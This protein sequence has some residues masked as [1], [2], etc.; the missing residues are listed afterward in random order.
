MSIEFHSGDAPPVGTPSFAP[1]VIDAAP[2]TP[3]GPAP[4]LLALGETFGGDFTG[5]SSVEDANRAALLIAQSYAQAG[6]VQHPPQPPQNSQAPTPPAAA[7]EEED[8]GDLDPK[9]IARLKRLDSDLKQTRAQAQQFQDRLTHDQLMLQQQQ[10]QDILNRALATIDSLADPRYG[11]AGNRSFTQDIARENLL[12]TADR[13][14][15]GMKSTGKSIP[16]I[17]K[18]VHMAVLAESG[19]LPTAK[20]AAAG[21]GSNGAPP[22]P[23]GGGSKDGA[24]APQQRRKTGTEVDS[25]LGDK[26]YMDGARAIVNR[27]R[28]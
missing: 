28:R 15:A 22:A 9:V 12:R 18:L 24:F 23:L 19:K 17:E 4:E 3:E 6:N 25:Y 14:V 1:P 13:I 27:G 21:G 11:V 5:F 2:E 26:D 20:A 16:A 7:V 8:F 10:H